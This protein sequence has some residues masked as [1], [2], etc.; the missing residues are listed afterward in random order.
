[1]GALRH[2][3]TGFLAGEID[4]LLS[5]RID[6]DHY[7]YGLD[8]CENFVPVN[9]GAIVK[10]PGFEYI[11]DA[12]PS[13]TWLSAFRYS[14]DQEYALEWGAGKLR[15]FTNGG[16]IETSPG[17]A[18][19]IA[20]P[21][22]AAH[23]PYLSTQQSYDRLY[24]DH[25]SYAPAAL[26][27][28]GAAT[29]AHAYSVLNNGPFKDQNI[30]QGITVTASG[31]AGSITLTATAPIFAAGHIGSLFQIEAEDFSTIKSW[32]AGMVGVV[33]GDQVRSEGKAY[34]ALTSGTTGT[35]TPVH[36]SGSEWDGQLRNDI[37]AKGPYGIQW[38]FLHDR[39]GV[40]RITSIGGGGTTATA[41]VVRR[42]PDQLLTVPSHRWSHSAFSAAEGW[43]NL[44]KH[45]FGRQLHIKGFD[46]IGSV[47]NDYGGGQVN[48]QAFT[49]SGTLAADLGFRRT[50]ATEDPPLW[51]AG[52]RRLLVGTASKELAIG[53]INTSLAVAGDNIQS[54]PQSFYGS[55]LVFPVQVGTETVFVERGGRRVRAAGYDFGRD[56][57]VPEDLTAAARAI[58]RGGVLQLALQRV[59]FQ[60]LYGV[61]GDGQLIVHPLTK[62]EVKGFGRT[63][64]GGGARA[65][66]AVSIV[67]ADNVTDELWLL[68]ERTRADGLKRE[69]WRQTPWREPGDPQDEQFFV[70]GGTRV[71]ASGGQTVFNGLTHL[72]GQPVWVL[73]GGG[74]IPG[75]TVSGGG[76][77]TL[78]PT[79]VPAA[80]YTLIVGLAYTATA[81]TL[82]PEAKMRSG[83]IQGLKQLVRKA[84]LRLLESVGIKVGSLDGPL[85]EVIDR[86]ANADMDAPI[87]LFTGDTQGL[88]DAQYTRDGR[89]RFVSDAPLAATIC[90]A[91]LSM[92]VDEADA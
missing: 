8:T 30:N 12:D 57:Y 74:V 16:R 5:G 69:I 58:T 70:D 7:A 60:L 21:Y 10:R 89:T 92:E 32:E 86:P 49:S 43:P 59:P 66:S 91:M 39:F 64:L 90:A 84:V 15:F 6:T 36:T 47:V 20:T 34:V 76:T 18:Y 29:F 44:V 14:I 38:Q 46:L 48:F 31:V 88:V 35:N 2:L 65:L 33:A 75:L 52:D 23:A 54:E 22:A 45:A 78:P 81:V 50:I 77:L 17:V 85:E 72:A 11:R 79:S 19:E 25:G 62:I 73:A 41:D 9:E 67:G 37:N 63:L 61:R 4:P 51:V 71:E 83:S 26:S 68:V 87:P 80:P 3:Q 53:A 27:R 28:T 42:L 24:I 56:R 82:R 55:Q 1:M 13:S 40:V